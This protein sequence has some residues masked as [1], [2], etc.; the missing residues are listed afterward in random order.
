MDRARPIGISGERIGI[1]GLELVSRGSFTSLP[2]KAQPHTAPR[3]APHRR[4]I[5]SMV[6]EH[7]DDGWFLLA[8]TLDVEIPMCVMAAG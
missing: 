3:G 1:V 2:H 4:L 5:W 7:S 8:E 6:R